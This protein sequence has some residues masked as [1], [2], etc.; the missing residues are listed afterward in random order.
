[1][2]PYS[3]FFQAKYCHHLFDVVARPVHHEWPN[4]CGVARVW[5]NLNTTHHL[6][7]KRLCILGPH[8]LK[9][10]RAKVSYRLHAATSQFRWDL[11]SSPTEREERAHGPFGPLH[12]RQFRNSKMLTFVA[13]F[14]VNDDV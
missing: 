7:Q 8:F 11:Y 13:P 12:G 10:L 6:F 14:I 1:V 3:F 2:K 5:Q 9:N 4:H